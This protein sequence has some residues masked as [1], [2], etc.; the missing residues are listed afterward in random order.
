MITDAAC[1]EGYTLS[2]EGQNCTGKP[3]SH[4]NKAPTVNGV[5][6]CIIFSPALQIYVVQIES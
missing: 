4:V 3:T 6:G 1:E 2:V 5:I